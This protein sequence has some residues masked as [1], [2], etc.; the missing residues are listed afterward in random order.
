MTLFIGLHADSDYAD[1]QLR[2]LAYAVKNSTTIVLPRWFQIL[3]ELRLTLRMIPR[4]VSTRWNSTYDMLTF[5][6]EHKSAITR[7]TSEQEMK[8]RKYE[9]DKKEWELIDQLCRAL[10]VCIIIF[11]ALSHPTFFQ[12]FKD[13][14]LFFLRDGTPNLPTVIP[15]MDYIDEAL[16]TNTLH[17]ARFSR[18]IQVALLMGKKTLNRYY[19]KTDQ[20]DLYRAA[21]SKLDLKI[22]APN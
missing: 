14:T 7:L 9:L 20:S 4:N 17:S 6:L 19:S 10:K 16:A 3:E 15:A 18:P 1:S 21:M 13:A 22:C 8:L 2:K 12:V 11:L 5:I